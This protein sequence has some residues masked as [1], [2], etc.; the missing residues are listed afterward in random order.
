M[1]Y[2]RNTSK[3]LSERDSERL[4]IKA[5][6]ISNRKMQNKQNSVVMMLIFEKEEF[7]TKSIKGEKGNFKML[8]LRV[9][10]RT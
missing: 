10:T 6:T 9:T 1:L 3:I 4:K 7:R 8:K 5:W 2:I